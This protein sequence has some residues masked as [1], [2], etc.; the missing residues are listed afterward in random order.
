MI[1]HERSA[2][3][4]QVAFIPLIRVA[5]ISSIRNTAEQCFN[6]RLVGGTSMRREIATFRWE[7]ARKMSPNTCIK[8]RERGW[9]QRGR[10]QASGL[11]NASRK[12]GT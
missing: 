11:E 1:F 5:R 3:V 7:R 9:L 6:Q 10:K 4:S 8:G 12:L 2:P